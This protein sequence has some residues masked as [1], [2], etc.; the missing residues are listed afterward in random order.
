MNFHSFLQLL[1]VCAALF[2]FAAHAEEPPALRWEP[3]HEPGGGGRIVSLAIDPNDVRHI[4]AGGDMLGA[5]VSFDGGD[6]W[7]PCQ[8][9]LCYEMCT[10]TFRPGR[11][12]EIWFGSC[13]GPLRSIDGGRT[14]QECRNG[15]P[16][17]ASSRY[18]A[19]IETVLFDPANSERLLAFGGSSRHWTQCDIFGSIWESVDDGASWRRL[20][21]LTSDGFVH[22]A[23]KGA[24]ITRAFFSNDGTL[25]IIADKIGWWRSP[26]GGRTW[27]RHLANGLVGP[28][29]SVAVHPKDTLGHMAQLQDGGLQR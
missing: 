4:V 6:S 26:D 28:V 5:A 21:T 16:P 10:P 12:G 27:R 18:T 17:S 20:G 8:G 7:T 15:M 24:N 29:T 25:H 3:L 13:S 14:W 11:Q 1:P 22:E 9:L 19:V 23:L 2:L